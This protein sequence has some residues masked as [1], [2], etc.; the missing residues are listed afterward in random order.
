[1]FFPNLPSTS[2]VFSGV[3]E[4]TETFPLISFNATKNLCLS[5]LNDFKIFFKL[6]LPYSNTPSIK[7]STDINSS[8]IDFACFSDS[9]NI[10]STSLE[11]LKATEPE[12][13]GILSISVFI[14]DSNVLTSTSIFLNNNVTIPCLSSKKAS[15][16]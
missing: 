13:L 16:K 11:N 9:S 3:S 5:I 15:I 14:T 12:T 4:F 6:S 7:C 1:M 2:Y 10:F 8:F